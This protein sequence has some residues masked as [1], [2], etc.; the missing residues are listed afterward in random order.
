MPYEWIDPELFLEYE[1]VAVYRCY[2]EDNVVSTY[3]YTT[4]ITDCNVDA[5][6]LEG[7]Q[8]DVRDLPDLGLEVNDP[9]NHRAIIRNAIG[10]GLI[11]GQPAI[12][13][14]P[15]HLVVKIEV[16]GGVAS[17]V[18]QPPGVEVV[19]IDLDV[20]AEPDPCHPDMS[21]MP[22]LATL[23][24]WEAEGGCEATDGCWTDSD[25]T[26]EHGCQSWL[27]VLGLI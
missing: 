15:P 8:F 6:E 4:E 14:E 20:A 18:E 13:S 23:R 24:E 12:S 26:C 21:K 19:I 5:P 17:V 9:K 10:Q 1:G 2:D 27:L 3:W 16:K 22:D 11:T 7:F 25:G